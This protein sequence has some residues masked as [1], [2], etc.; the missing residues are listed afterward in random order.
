MKSARKALRMKEREVMEAKAEY[1]GAKKELKRRGRA[2]ESLRGTTDS[3]AS[4]E[5]R[6][7]KEELDK[8]E[9]DVWEEQKKIES[10]KHSPK[11][12]KS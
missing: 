6:V 3:G 5:L 10:I 9:H 11:W 12:T 8:A 2:M 4:G 7:A 1:N